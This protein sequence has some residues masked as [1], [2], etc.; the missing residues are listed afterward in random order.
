MSTGTG[1]HQTH[2]GL[3]KVI[4]VDETTLAVKIHTHSQTHFHVHDKTHTA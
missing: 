4:A 1:A 3:E 2:N